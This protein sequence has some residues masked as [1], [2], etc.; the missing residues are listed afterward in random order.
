MVAEWLLG[1][2]WH[3]HVQEGQMGVLLNWFSSGLSQIELMWL[4]LSLWVLC[5][6]RAVILVWQIKLSCVLSVSV[7]HSLISQHIYVVRVSVHSD[8][9]SALHPTP[10]HH[11][12][13]AGRYCTTLSCSLKGWVSCRTNAMREKSLKSYWKGFPSSH[14]KK[15][16]ETPT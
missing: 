12:H 7:S 3:I 4:L 6:H 9:L 10:H 8:A 1:T 2:R 5:W 13:I 14:V 15:S 11:H 16:L